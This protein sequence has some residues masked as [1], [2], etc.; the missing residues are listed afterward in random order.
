MATGQIAHSSSVGATLLALVAC[1]CGSASA[2]CQNIDGGAVELSWRLRPESGQTPN[3]PCDPFVCCDSLQPGTNPVDRIVLSW[4]VDGEGSSASW[5]CSSGNGV[6]RFDVPPGDALLSI[7]PV[8]KD[9]DADPST[10]IAPA[11]EERTITI[12]NT[13]S[14]GAVEVLLRISSCDVQ[15]CICQ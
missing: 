12:G 6:T 8:C 10:Y 7:A 15:P 9:H 1:A 4:V 3:N 2:G 13:V 11:A 5:D 14:L